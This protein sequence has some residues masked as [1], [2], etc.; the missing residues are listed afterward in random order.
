MSPAGSK[1][2]SCTNL[3]CMLHEEEEKIIQI[4]QKCMI[5]KGL[6]NKFKQNIGDFVMREEKKRII[7][8]NFSYIYLYL[9]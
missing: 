9:V 6:W 5:L 3:Y 1:N 2:I 4:I 7:K 8:L